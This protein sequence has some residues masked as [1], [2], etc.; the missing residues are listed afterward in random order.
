MENY[1][2]A[3]WSNY[4]I[5]ST[6]IVT[7]ALLA[8]SYWTVRMVK[9][10]GAEMKI[11]GFSLIAIMIGAIMFSYLLAPKGYLIDTDKLI[12]IRP[13]RSITIPLAGVSGAEA[14]AP[15]LFS[16]SIRVLGSGGLWGYY[17]KYQSTPLGRYYMYARRTSELVLVKGRENYVVAPERPQEFIQI[18][19]RVILANKP[20]EFAK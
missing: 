14:A 15:E 5:A 3:E 18:L 6:A 4:L 17:G 7:A 16:D 19:N 20:K 1:F 13:L 9:A 8:S 10:P 12:I 2:K 11:M